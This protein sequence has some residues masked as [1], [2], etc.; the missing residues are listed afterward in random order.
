MKTTK[1]KS[2]IRSLPL[3]K[4][5]WLLYIFLNTTAGQNK[6]IQ[7]VRLDQGDTTLNTGLR[8]P[9]LASEHQVFVRVDE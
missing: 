3:Y 1:N 7:E 2:F 4:A 6:N 5:N 9:L 8:E